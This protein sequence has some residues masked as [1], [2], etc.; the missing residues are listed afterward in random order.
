MS[1]SFN[2]S[3][4]VASC[5]VSAIASLILSMATDEKNDSEKFLNSLPLERR[6]IVAAKYIS[7]SIVVIIAVLSALAVVWMMRGLTL[8]ADIGLYHPY[9]YIELPWDTVLRGIVAPFLY[10]AFF[11][12]VY[13]GTDSK[14]LRGILA[15]VIVVPS[16][17]ISLFIDGDQYGVENSFSN[18]IMNMSNVGICIVG[19]MGLAAIYIISMFMAIKLYEKEIYKGGE[20]S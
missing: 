11:L 2:S 3:V 14:V 1:N 12:P 19:A 5:L 8:I 20:E 17:I 10:V 18:W 7:I 6:N 9:I 13:Y 16:T 4:F 15:I